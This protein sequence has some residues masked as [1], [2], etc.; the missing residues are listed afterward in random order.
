MCINK[1]SLRYLYVIYERVFFIKGD[2]LK[3]GLPFNR[4]LQLLKRLLM[5]LRL[6]FRL[7]LAML[8]YYYV[9]N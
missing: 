6:R 7:R 3:T 1:I 4:R 2:V 9:N 8:G 5:A